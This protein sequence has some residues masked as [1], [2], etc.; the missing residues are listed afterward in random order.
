MDM[1]KYSG[2]SFIKFEDVANSTRTEEILEVRE[3][4][5]GRPVLE[6]A[7]GDSFSLNTTNNRTLCKFY[8]EDSRDWIGS[9]IELYAG[10]TDFKGEKRDSV[11]VRPI[12][13]AKPFKERHVP[14][15]EDKPTI[16]LAD[17]IPF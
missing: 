14:E 10:Q 3:G 4:N 15:P 16:Q 9:T 12:T 2:E 17:D 13:P 7:S 8:G 5:Y 6:F 11:L 1:S